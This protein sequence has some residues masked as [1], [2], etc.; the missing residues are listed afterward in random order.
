MNKIFKILL[1]ITTCFFLISW[2]KQQ[3]DEFTFQRGNQKLTLELGNGKRI[4]N[5][6]VESTLKLRYENIDPKKMT[7]SAP[8]ISFLKSDN[9][10]IAVLRI[11]PEKNLINNDTLKLL[12]NA[13]DV[14]DS[15]WFHEFKIIVKP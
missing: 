3:I 15:I 12:I 1:T 9:K 14:N 2:I 4:L 7:F 13:R 5:W 10:N 6:N 8:G 11:K